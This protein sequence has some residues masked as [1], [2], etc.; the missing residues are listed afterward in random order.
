M[1]VRKLTAAAMA[2]TAVTLCIVSSSAIVLAQDKMGDK[3][4]PM[5][6]GMTKG[7]MMS[8]TMPPGVYVCKMCKGYYSATDARKMKMMD[9]MGHKL[10]MMKKAPAGYKMM[11]MGDKMGHDK[12]MNHGKTKPGGARM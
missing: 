5:K 3:K 4:M 10:V 1:N 9:P 7:K 8:Q 2:A 11:K 12:M 6:S